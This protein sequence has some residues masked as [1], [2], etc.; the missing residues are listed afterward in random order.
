M[1]AFIQDIRYG[2]RML[3]R[4]PGATAV[5]ILSL[6]LG[7]GA[8]ST[9]F[10][11]VDGVFLR[12]WPV[13]APEE[14]VLVTSLTEG[15][16]G[17]GSSYQDFIDLQE[18]CTV[19]S[20][21]LAFGKRG[22]IL[23][24]QGRGEM[25][26]TDVV[27]E[28]Y[29]S[30]LGVEPVVGSAFVSGEGNVPGVVISYG[31]WQ[32]RFAGDPGLVGNTVNL[33]G[34]HLTVLGVAPPEFRGLDPMVATGAWVTPA[35]WGVMTGDRVELERRDNRWLQVVGR[36]GPGVDVQEAK[37]QLD[38]IAARLAASFP[39]T[40]DKST[41]YAVL[42]SE[43]R[44]GNLGITMFIMSMVGLVLLISCANVANLQLAQ[45]EKRRGEMAMRA[46]LGAKSGR[47]VRQLLTESMLLAILGGILGLLL[48]TWLIRLIPDLMPP[49]QVPL[50]PDI[51]LDRRVFMFTGFCALMTSLIFGIIPAMRAAKTDLVSTIKG[52]GAPLVR[53]RGGISTRSVLV[54]AE[55]ALSLVLI[56]SAGLLLRSLWMSQRIHPGF[57]AKKNM[58][59]VQIAPAVLYGY[60]PAQSEALFESLVERI[61]SVPGV[62][63][64]SY[65]RRP[66]LA[67]YEG[68][69]RRKVFIP[70]YSPPSGE[71]AVR[72]RFNTVALGYFETMG[73]RLLRG[74]DFDR[75]D[76]PESTNVVIVNETMAEEFWPGGGAVD[77]W[78]RI[79]DQE[80]LIIGV[81]ED[82]RYVNIHEDPQ[83]YLFLPFAQNFSASASFFVEM[84]GDRQAILT[85][86][87]S[88]ARALDDS[89]PVTDV[90]TLARHM[91]FALYE[92]RIAA[93]LIGSLGV[94]GILLAAVGLYGVV[95][96]MVSRRTREVGVRMA[97]GARPGDVL[98]L[99]LGHVLRLVLAGLLAGVGASLAVS[100]LMT[101][102]LFGVAPTD[103][104][105]Y[106]GS[107]LLVAAIS[108]MAASHP[109]LRATRID[110]MRVLRYE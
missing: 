21:V 57:D 92:D 18:Q 87:L 34:K 65:A 85:A 25:V 11:I 48:A 108:F 33:S 47:V 79:R 84:S 15:K 91:Q 3:S 61:R 27:S 19:F 14:L 56:T 4:S 36:L 70:G 90:V 7:I 62:P 40:N 89:V 81:V 77:Q 13:S 32:R 101:G 5:S 31:L 110:P 103:P 10:S 98:K 55:I 20:G 71:E 63:S 49:A 68:G 74:R 95:S 1:G 75:R 45:T 102:Y 39:G 9:I 100:R 24:H 53:R 38:T 54:S 16:R 2:L 64:A 44:R 76:G 46:A 12:S 86:I 30:V 73:T 78:I 52:V 42:E 58:M 37:A 51:R 17:Y 82:G 41:F 94:L 26:L 99:V 6:A 29:F 83:P 28:S 22:S 107:A 105:T 72:I 60:S 93:L 80:C 67:G 106:V 66:P 96:Y 69:E 23:S 35:G 109:S 8:T 43:Q 88:E 59:L 104:I 50:G 97:L